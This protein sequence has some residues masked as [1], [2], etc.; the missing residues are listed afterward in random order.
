MDHPEN[1]LHWVHY[2]QSSQ[3]QNKT[4]NRTLKNSNTVTT[5]E[6]GMI[7]SAREYCI[8]LYQYNWRLQN[9]KNS[10]CDISILNPLNLTQ[11]RGG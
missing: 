6:L 9:E 3:K 4:Q 7:L 5:K 10:T 8:P 1:W 2:S 11:M